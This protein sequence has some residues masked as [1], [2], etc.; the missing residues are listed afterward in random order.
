[1]GQDAQSGG[2]CGGGA[3]GQRN[4]D[5]R[6]D[7]RPPAGHASPA[8]LHLT[9]FGIELVVVVPYRQQMDKEIRRRSIQG[10]VGKYAREIRLLLNGD[11]SVQRICHRLRARRPIAPQEFPASHQYRAGG[12]FVAR[13]WCAPRAISKAFSRRCTQ[14]LRDGTRHRTCI[15]KPRCGESGYSGHDDPIASS[16]RPKTQLLSPA[17]SR[18]E[19]RGK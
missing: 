1:M 12:L 19:P 5:A 14:K 9:P 6:H 11:G 7:L 2:V 17:P 15:A 4:G 10:S 16:G 8:N 18:Q 13:N 3:C